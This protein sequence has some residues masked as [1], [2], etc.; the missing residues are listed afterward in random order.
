MPT[1]IFK[2]SMLY[3]FLLFFCESCVSCCVNCRLHEKSVTSVSCRTQQ[4]Q[5][6][7]NTS[8]ASFTRGRR[9]HG[10][11]HLQDSAVDRWTRRR[12][13]VSRWRHV[14]VKTTRS[15]EWSS[16][17]RHLQ[18]LTYANI[19]CQNCRNIQ[20]EWCLLMFSH[21]AVYFTLWD[22]PRAFHAS[23]PLKWH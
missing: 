4:N 2:N 20:R 12:L 17:L 6:V 14:V 18:G 23:H 8:V 19:D 5:R 15:R 9:G 1:N 11:S 21:C 22:S 16:A 13:A 10:Q 7:V 3:I